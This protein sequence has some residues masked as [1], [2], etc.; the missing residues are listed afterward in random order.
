MRSA[1]MLQWLRIAWFRR[2]WSC[3]TVQGEPRLVSPAL[4]CGAGSI[5]FEN[6]VTLGW[7][8]GPSFFSGYTYMEARHADSSVRL[9]AGT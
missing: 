1:Q 7:E 6:E 3:R 4:L 9:G 5:S 2:P 8:Q